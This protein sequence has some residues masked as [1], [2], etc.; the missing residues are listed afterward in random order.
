MMNYEEIKKLNLL[1]KKEN[2]TSKLGLMHCVSN[3]PATFKEL[4]LNSIN[5]LQKNF[6]IFLLVIRTIQTE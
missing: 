3:Y 2:F 5:F 6:Q 1:I 4:N